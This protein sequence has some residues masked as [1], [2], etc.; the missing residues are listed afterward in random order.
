[1]HIDRWP[2]FLLVLIDALLFDI[3]FAFVSLQ[4]LPPI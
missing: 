1:M 4:A 3:S 2:R